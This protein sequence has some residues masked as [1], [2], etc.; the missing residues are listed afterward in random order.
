M[1]GLIEIALMIVFQYLTAH[2]YGIDDHEWNFPVFPSNLMNID[3]QAFVQNIQGIPKK[4]WVARR[5]RPRQESEMPEHIQKMFARARNDGWEASVQSNEDQLAF[6]EEHY[7][8]TSTLWAFKIINPR[9][10][11]VGCDIWRV[12]LLYAVGGFYLDDDSYIESSLN[13]II[14]Q[15]DT[16]IV[17][18]EKNL[19]RETC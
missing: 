18:A 5:R 17:T 1:W 2:I 15:N 3:E 9:L 10:G 16:L 14:G 11:V 7:P 6:M 19:Y 8:N 13:S 4:M 12:A